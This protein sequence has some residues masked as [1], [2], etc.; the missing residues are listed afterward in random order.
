MT[1]LSVEGLAALEVE[2]RRQLEYINYPARNWMPEKLGPDGQRVIDVAIIGGGQSGLSLAHSLFR[3]G[4]RTITVFDQQEPR[5]E[6]PWVT[7]ARMKTLRTGK[8]LTGPD[9]GLPALTFRAWFEA[10]HGAT[11]W[12]ELKQIDRTMWMDYLIWYRTVLDLPVVNHA[13][14]RKITPVDGLL[15]LTFDFPDGPSVRYARKLVLATG[16]DGAGAAR[17]PETVDPAL[18]RDRFAHS[19]DNIDFAALEGRRVAVIGSRDAAWDNAATAAE[20]G[21]AQVHLLSRRPHLAQVHKFRAMRFSAYQRGYPKLPETQRLRISR[22]AFGI[23]V[24]PPTESV[25]RLTRLPN[26]KVHLNASCRRVY[27]TSD[28][29][30]VDTAAGRFDVDYVIFGTGASVDLHS[31]PELAP[32][33]DQIALWKHRFPPSDQGEAREL[34]FG[35]FPYLDAGFQFQEKEPGT[36]PFLRDI[37]CF[38]FGS[39]MSLGSIVGDIPGLR[40]GVERISAALV[41]DLFTAD[42]EHHLA[43]LRETNEDELAGTDYYVPR[44]NRVEYDL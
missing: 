2:L 36:A 37:F 1:R 29:V 12:R 35:L 38:N 9:M 25:L 24:A 18:G 14:L 44:P 17:I 3:E 23:Q 41:E 30:A 34:G 10:Q 15:A 31:R 43:V 16:R 27:P 21:A 22:Y 19:T 32:F 26:V 42:L 5:H 8:S 39:S 11:A 13:R 7:Y 33:A 20:A 28:G 40:A 6:G 4:I